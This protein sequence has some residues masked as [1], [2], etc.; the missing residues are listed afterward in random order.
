MSIEA[1]ATF[2]GRP[3]SALDWRLFAFGFPL[4]LLVLGLSTGDV[5]AGTLQIAAIA[6]FLWATLLLFSAQREGV[7]FEVAFVPLAPHYVQACVQLCIYLYWG[8]YWRPVYDHAVL[9]LAQL[10]FAYSLD[11]MLSLTRRRKWVLGFGP[12]PIILSTN[13]FLLFR[14]EWFYLQ[15]ALV[16]VGILGKEFIR[17]E[18]DGRNTHIFNPSAF[19]LFVFS[20][21]LIL[22]GNT[23]WTFAEEIATTLNRP[24][25][26]YL[27]IFLLG[28]V[29][30]YL[31]AVTLVTLAA[32][33][34]LVVLNVVYQQLTGVYFFIDSS[35]PI[36]VFLGLHLLV[37]D[38][39]TSPRT[40]AG[41]ALF[42]VLYGAGV[43]GLYGLL[44]L[45]GA[46]TFYDKLLCVPVLN[47]MVPWIDAAARK[48]RAYPLG[49]LIGF[50]EITRKANLTHMAIWILV[51]SVMLG[52]AFVGP[53]HRGNDTAFWIDACKEQRRNACTVLLDIYR[54]ECGT[55]ASSACGKGAALLQQQPELADRVET[56]K[57]L[58]R[59]CDVGNRQVCAL[60]RAHMAGDQG[61]A[62]ASACDQGDAVACYV[63]GLVAMNGV[64][65]ERDA[66]AAAGFWRLACDGGWA[67]A[68]GDLGEA[69]LIGKG[70]SADPRSALGFFTRACD[71][72]FQ[73]SCT[74]LG[75]MYR[76]GHG[77]DQDIERGNE[78]IQGAC[79]SGWTLACDQL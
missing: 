77:V 8:W 11:L 16:A 52:T 23:S 69:F 38:P 28:L 58:A 9:I 55:G 3:P 50:S 31:F 76:R 22:S 17:W 18:R 30:Q 7:G 72:G 66:L 53:G 15:F 41:K 29:V 46:P 65:V 74:T 59:G 14:P 78:L 35:I 42:G 63:S 40:A 75:L 27:Q 39:A 4:V 56:G 10:V 45:F 61:Q 13:L 6:M 26:I 12:F 33:L 49:E 24:P 1:S 32:A 60:F 36:A 44:G 54:A 5:V 64:G 51:F 34:S 71:A 67:R 37:T 20:V 79:D 70:V 25:D 62:M 21:F 2:P 73:P 47:L 57:F 68:C 48:L 43:F 19:T